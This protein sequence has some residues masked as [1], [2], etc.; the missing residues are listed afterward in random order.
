MFARVVPELILLAKTSTMNSKH[1]A[2]LI[3]GKHVLATGTNYSLPAGELIDSVT[4]TKKFPSRFIERNCS[5]PFLYAQ[6]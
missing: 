4:S 5:G 2:A 3:S 6:V 1:A